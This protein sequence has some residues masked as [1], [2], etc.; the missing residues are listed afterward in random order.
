MDQSK[1]EKVMKKSRQANHSFNPE[2][3]ERLKKQ[4]FLFDDSAT[5]N[6]ETQEKIQTFFNTKGQL[7]QELMTVDTS[8]FY[9]KENMIEALKKKLE[10]LQAL[11]GKKEVLGGTRNIQGN[12]LP[13]NVYIIPVPDSDR[14]I[15]IAGESH[16]RENYNY[17]YGNPWGSY[18]KE[19]IQSANV[20]TY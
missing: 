20:R 16:Q 10:L 15:K 5:S 19:A 7:V 12:E 9:S 18:L 4:Q 13:R 14:V 6:P 11:S 8:A 17:M 3:I 1:F 2:V